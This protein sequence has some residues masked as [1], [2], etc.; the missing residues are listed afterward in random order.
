MI[1]LLLDSLLKTD[2]ALQY[3]V[4]LHLRR[5][6]ILRSPHL[7][8]KWLFSH[9]FKSS[10]YVCREK[11]IKILSVPSS[12][13]GSGIFHRF[14]ILFCIMCTGKI[15]L[16]CPISKRFSI[17]SL[18]FCKLRPPYNLTPAAKRTKRIETHWKPREDP[19]ARHAAPASHKLVF[20]RLYSMCF[21][22]FSRVRIRG[23]TGSRFD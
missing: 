20:P 22:R 7:T 13:D 2:I 21:S 6:W 15:V 1:F 4:M 14:S 8:T 11:S 12:R 5:S 3:A 10:Y 23:I 16:C 19:T 9:H 18:D 17:D